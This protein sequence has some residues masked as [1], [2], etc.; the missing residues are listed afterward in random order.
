ME[1]VDNGGDHACVG[2]LGV[3][4]KSLYLL[5]NPAVNLKPL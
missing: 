2:A 3:Y 1:D 5:F 4:G